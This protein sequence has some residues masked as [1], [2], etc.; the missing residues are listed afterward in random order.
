MTT[1]YS[2]IIKMQDFLPV[3]DIMDEN[4][5]AWQSF[6]PTKQFCVLLRESLTAITSKEVSKRKSVW[7]RGTFGTGKSHAGSVVKHLL[8][9]DFEEVADYIE[10]IPDE[11]LKA[12]IRNLR[13]GGRKYF[14]V[15][16]KGVEKAYDIPHFTLALQRATKEAIQKQHPDFTVQSDFLTA[17]KWIKDHRSIFESILK[18]DEELMSNFDTADQVL[19]RLEACDSTT[20]LMV[21][22]AVAEGIGTVFQ[23]E[24][25][26]DWLVEVEKEIEQRAI[27]NGLIIFWDEFTSVMDTLKSD[28]INLL[29]NIAEKSQKNNVFL[30]LISHR[31]ELSNSSENKADDIS[32]MSDRYVHIPYSMDEVSTYVIMRHSYIIPSAAG[33][34]EFNKIFGAISEKIDAT[35]DFVTDKNA[36]QRSTISKLLPM[37]P[38]TAYLCSSISN[39]VGSS[40]RSVIKFMHDEQDGFHAFLE[41]EEN[42]NTNTLLTADALWDFFYSEFEEDVT[43][44]TFT[45]LFKSFK[46]KVEAEGEDYLRVFKTVLLLNAL[47]PKFKNDP[48]KLSPEDKVFEYIFA[49]DRVADK[50]IDILNWLDEKKVVV[51]DPFGRFKITGSSYNQAEMNAKRQQVTSNYRVADNVLQYDIASLEEVKDLFKVGET[52]RRETLVQFFSCEESEALVRSKLNKFTQGKPN[53]LHVAIFLSIKESDRDGFNIILKNLSK[54]YENLVLV[55]PDESF[56]ENTYTRFIDSIAHSMVAESHFNKTEAKEYENNA[57]QFVKKWVA[58]L[59]KNTY[60]TYFNCQAYNEGTFEQIPDLLNFKLSVKAYPYGFESVKEFGKKGIKDNFFVDK[61]CPKIIEQILEAQ[62]SSAITSFGGN[63]DPIKYI[64]EDHGITLLRPNGELSDNALHSDVWITNVC[65]RMDKCIADAKAKYHDRFSLGDVL[66]PF[67]TEPFGFFTSFANCAAL[68]YAIRVHKGDLFIPGVSQPISDDKLRDMLVEVFKAWTKDG[69]TD[70]NKFLLRF[71][72]PEET[73]LKDL[74]IDIFELHK[75]KNVKEIKSLDN[76][77]WAVQEFCKIV[78]GQPLWTL[79]HLDNGTISEDQK[80]AIR[81]LIAVFSAESVSIDKIKATYKKLNADHVALNII[82]TNTANYQNGFKAFVKSIEEAPI[83]LEWWD[84]MLEFINTLQ[85][86]IAF[87]QESQVRQKIVAFYI[88]KTAPVPSPVPTHQLGTDSQPTPT[89]THPDKVKVAKDKIKSMNMPNMMWQRLALDLLNERPD[90]ADF[91]ANLS[92]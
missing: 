32:K 53:Y 56:S 88:K 55:L 20:Y 65:K 14:A 39:F 42:F 31:I 60:S 52:V 22:R 87:R 84:E 82:F 13:Q 67:V 26:S 51:R 7:V 4:P 8:C 28:R 18:E 3:Y 48:E 12:Q 75:V 44:T 10:S 49:G 72:S 91:F 50:V 92:I 54:E 68:A 40:N 34:A 58:A 83:K 1:K 19:N 64:F 63:P 16:L 85:L 89:P 41:K 66:A 47:L 78:T 24:G 73:Q 37:H 80:E 76:A 36:E 62:T 27:G 86:E 69:K 17:S 21:E 2:D 43:S 11:A 33:N 6:I 15:M 71:G 59:K 25:I 57:H 46:G 74:L 30:F 9:D 5:K 70:S 23:H 45:N 38:Y 90:L 79:L 29:Q 77:K 35:L 81:D 61:N